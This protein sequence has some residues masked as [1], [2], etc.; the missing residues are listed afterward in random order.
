MLLSV[1]LTWVVLSASC[2]TPAEVI[3]QLTWKVSSA[4]GMVTG[5]VTARLG[6]S[7]DTVSGRPAGR[8][9]AGAQ[10]RRR[11]G[12]QGARLAPRAASLP[13]HARGHSLAARTHALL[14][15]D[16]LEPA[17]AVARPARILAIG[18]GASYF[19][20][21]NS[22][23]LHAMYKLR[24]VRAY[25]GA[26]NPHR[27]K[28][29]HRFTGFDEQDDMPM[30]SAQ[31]AKAAARR[32]HGAESGRRRQPRVAAAQGG[33]VHLDTSAHRQLPHRLS[34]VARIRRPLQD[35]ARERRRS[36]SAPS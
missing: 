15:V 10:R 21:V 22:F 4:L 24:L 33:I 12:G 6:G 23:S 17:G 16:S 2:C 34:A 8:S 27:A 11:A 14:P 32:Q 3:Q 30:C 7:S 1:A 31:R 9:R 36:R 25:L 26:S 35:V 13:V 29:A 5:W 20:N 19:I 18:I 28:G